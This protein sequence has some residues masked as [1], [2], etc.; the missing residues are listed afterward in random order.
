MV[1]VPAAVWVDEEGRIVRPSEVAYSKEQQVLGNT[2]G[3]NRYISGLRD[4]VAQG[5][6]SR[7]VM[8]PEKLKELLR[9]KPPELRLAD[10]HFKL[11]THFHALG[12]SGEAAVHW[13]VAQELHPNSWNYHRQEWSFDPTTAGQKW[14]QKFRALNGQP[15]YAPLDLPEEE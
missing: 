8:S 7:F 4:W 13:K 2:I 10:A 1:N 6:K 11:A 9:T 15:Y 5:K 12:D 14:F 3:N